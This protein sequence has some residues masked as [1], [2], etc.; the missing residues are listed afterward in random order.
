MRNEFLVLLTLASLASAPFAKADDG[1]EFV[2]SIGFGLNYNALESESAD[3]TAAFGGMT[4]SA[5]LELPFY[6]TTGFGLG[7]F[8]R[9]TAL[10]LRNGASN[11]QDEENLRGSDL[12][13]GVLARTG[14]FGLTVGG[15]YVLGRLD[16]RSGSV[17][18]SESISG[19]LPMVRLSYRIRPR[20]SKIY[21]EP[22][23]S[24]Q[25]GRLTGT[26][27]GYQVRGTRIGLRTGIEF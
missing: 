12:T 18:S 1:K 4:Y 2:R 3:A 22:C 14:R 25:T 13:V 11:D 21:L 20:N 9:F 24:Y 16:S 7:L 23:A 15:D 19:F 6:E 5:A 27:K 26:S 10:D 17:N 8:S